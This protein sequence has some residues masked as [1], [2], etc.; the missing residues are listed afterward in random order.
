METSTF[1][2]EFSS[3]QPAQRELSMAS[4]G[5]ADRTIDGLTESILW[6]G[7]ADEVMSQ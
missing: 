1:L 6:I 2:P 3:F 4:E 5:E 7:E